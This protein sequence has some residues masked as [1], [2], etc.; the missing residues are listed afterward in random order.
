MSK[1]RNSQPL[2]RV[3]AGC[4][5]GV[6]LGSG[7]LGGAGIATADPGTESGVTNDSGSTGGTTAPS[8]DLERRA[9]KSIT[10]RKE[11]GV[12]TPQLFQAIP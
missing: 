2:T 3:L 6:G 1:S 8:R 12:S 4:I 5:I 10:I 11:V 9:Y 7:L